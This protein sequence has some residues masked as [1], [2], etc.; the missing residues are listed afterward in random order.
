[1]SLEIAWEQHEGY[2]ALRMA[3]SPSLGQML[4][5]IELMAVETAE[6]PHGRLL[7]DLRG[8][9]SLTSFTE[10]F[11]V[12]EQA[13]AKL[14]H[15]RKVASVVPPERITRNS[16]RPARKKGLNLVVFSSEPQAV[17]WLLAPD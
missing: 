10:Q 6:W 11:A 4:S 16:E 13:A 8:V 9:T 12:G 14:A 15:L 17:E 5:C 3:G 2:G 1:M 7:V